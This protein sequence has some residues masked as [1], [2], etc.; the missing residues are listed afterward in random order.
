VVIASLAQYPDDVPECGLLLWQHLVGYLSIFLMSL[1][2]ELM[3]TLSAL[4]GS[5]LDTDKRKIVPNLIY[6]R[7]GKSYY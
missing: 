5:I 6:L 3:I 4:R 7:L 1:L 2:L